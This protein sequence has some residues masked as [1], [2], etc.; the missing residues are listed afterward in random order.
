M[1][2]IVGY[3]APWSVHCT[4]VGKYRYSYPTAH[5]VCIPQIYCKEYVGILY[6]KKNT[7]LLSRDAIIPAGASNG[8]KRNKQLLTS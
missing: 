3:N 1:N 8:A 4:H 5:T 2:C 6:W 7:Y